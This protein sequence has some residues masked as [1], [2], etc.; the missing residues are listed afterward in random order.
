MIDYIK[1]DEKKLIAN[2][3]DGCEEAFKSVYIYYYKRLCVY[4]LNFT[5]DRD[6]TEDI[7]Q[8]TFF[9][10]WNH[11]ETLRVDCSLSGYLYR[12]TY[13]NFIDACREKKKQ[14][15]QLENLRVHVLSNLLDDDDLFNQRLQ[16]VKSAIDQLPPRCKEIFLLNKQSGMRY[17]EIAEHLG[18]SVKTVENQ[19]GKALNIIR[20]KIDNKIDIMLLMIFGHDIDFF[21][22]KCRLGK[23]RIFNQ[24]T[25]K[26]RLLGTRIN[27]QEGSKKIVW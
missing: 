8:D 22:R 19:I 5:G 7:V 16:K 12:I 14:D 15:N 26:E 2:I 17:K 23:E 6:L 21:K 24:R 18:L 4:I 10:L 11:R 13:N 25:Q 1:T 9:K 3:K 27:P 20:Q